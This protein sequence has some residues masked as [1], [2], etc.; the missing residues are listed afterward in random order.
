MQVVETGQPTPVLL[1]AL[2]PR[3]HLVEVEVDHLCVTSRLVLPSA[4][5]NTI[6]A[7]LATRASTVPA[8]VHDSMG[9]H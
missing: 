1:V 4:A 5:I 8:R 2:S 3:T 9:M 6:R 7:H